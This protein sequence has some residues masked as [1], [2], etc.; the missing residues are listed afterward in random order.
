MKTTN[1]AQY[2]ATAANTSCLR[3]L[4]KTETAIAN[5]RAKES[6]IDAITFVEKVKLRKR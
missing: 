6:V 5:T 2:A 4:V 1:T 3:A